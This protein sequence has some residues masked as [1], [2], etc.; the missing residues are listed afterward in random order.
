MEEIKNKTPKKLLVEF[1]P[2]SSM[3]AL[4]VKSLQMFLTFSW[5]WSFVVAVSLL[6][7]GPDGKTKLK[8]SLPLFLAFTFSPLNQRIFWLL[9]FTW[10]SCSD[11][12]GLYQMGSQ[13]LWNFICPWQLLYLLSQCH[14]AGFIGLL[15]DE[16]SDHF[17]ILNGTLNLLLDYSM[18]GI[19]LADLKHI[20][21]VCHT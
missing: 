5:F 4:K 17:S 20:K 2:V 9:C 12:G 7:L 6:V 16:I 11:H 1:L 10:L 21:S 3:G 19:T 18:V 15:T 14:P 8:P 13:L